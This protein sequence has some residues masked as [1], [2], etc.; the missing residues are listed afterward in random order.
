MT[1]D[2]GALLIVF[3]LEIYNT[4][5]ELISKSL[6]NLTQSTE[7]DVLPLNSLDKKTVGTTDV[8]FNNTTKYYVIPFTQLISFIQDI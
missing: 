4:I 8:T 7:G 5:Q 1:G 6:R 2:N 3:L